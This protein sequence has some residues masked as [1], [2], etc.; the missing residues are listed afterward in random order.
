MDCASCDYPFDHPINMK[1]YAPSPQVL[2]TA[3][4]DEDLLKN[5]VSNHTSYGEDVTAMSKQAMKAYR[6]AKKA[7]EVQN[8]RS[9]R[10]CAEMRSK[11]DGIDHPFEPVI[12]EESV[13]KIQ[14]SLNDF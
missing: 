5:D 7:S 3:I 12:I 10:I 8:I 9:R 11:H 4:S 13:P 2:E 1:T 6:R 14:T